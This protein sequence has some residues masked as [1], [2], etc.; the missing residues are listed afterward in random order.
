V[1]RTY[2]VNGYINAVR[3]RTSPTLLV[4]GATD[5]D[6]MHR[7]VAERTPASNRHYNID[8]SAIFNDISLYGQG[9]K[10]KVLA[11]TAEVQRLTPQFKKLSSSFACLVDREWDGLQSDPSAAVEK[12]IEPQQLP[13][14]Y[15]TMGHSIENY[16]FQP[17]CFLDY[18]RNGFAEHFSGEV[19]GSVR[20]HFPSAVALAGAF[21]CQ[22]RD[23]QSITRLSGLISLT[24]IELSGN[25]RFYLAHDAILQ[26]S[27]RLGFDGSSFVADVNAAIDSHW[28]D[29]SNNPHARWVLHGHIGSE[30]LWACVGLVASAAGVPVK[31][32]EQ[33]AKGFLAERR[34]CCLTWLSRV[35]QCDKEPLDQAVDW[36]LSPPPADA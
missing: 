27:T 32:G 23:S 11:V 12:W 16:N 15:V 2:S 8:H 29:L 5:K 3:Q 4:E 18:L 31:I 30:I 22:A 10:A 24:H 26:I 28:S 33:I 36:L 17:D 7:L 19:E 35:P 14:A 21:T 13:T 25:G 1:G 34:R 9:A 6:A 20:R